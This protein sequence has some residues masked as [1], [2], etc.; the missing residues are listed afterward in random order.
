MPHI[1][2]IWEAVA[3]LW[4][5]G[6]VT[7]PHRSRCG[8]IV[9][10]LHDLEATAE[11]LHRRYANY[12]REWPDIE[13]TPE[14]LVKHW[15]RF[16]KQHQAAAPRLEVQNPQYEMPSEEE[17]LMGQRAFRAWK[18]QKYGKLG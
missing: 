14:A 18:E 17:R 2:P 12:R 16:A 9:R 3:Q 11:E 10:D 4:F 1:D 8:K 6:N 5:G 7:R 13:C 15:C